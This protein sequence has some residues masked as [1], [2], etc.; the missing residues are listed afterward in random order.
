MK[1]R[2]EEK[3]RLYL[4]EKGLLLNGY[5]SF[6]IRTE[7]GQEYDLIKLLAEFKNYDTEDRSVLVVWNGYNES[8]KGHVIDDGFG[9]TAYLKREPYWKDKNPTIM[10]NIFNKLIRA[11][12][13]TVAVLI[14]VMA[15]FAVAVLVGS[16]LHKYVLTDEGMIWYGLATLILFGLYLRPITRD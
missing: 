9:Y 6:R 15:F 16:L 3:A 7:K 2:N 1:A 8:A 5:N 10:R 12:N 11:T 14:Y 4:A 13:Q